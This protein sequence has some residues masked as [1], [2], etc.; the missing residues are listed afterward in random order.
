MTLAS[1]KSAI[2]VALIA[3]YRTNAPY[4]PLVVP[5]PQEVRVRMTGPENPTLEGSGVL[6]DDS[7]RASPT[8][9]AGLSQSTAK[10]N[11]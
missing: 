6:L 10:C 2:R 8:C 3:F 11:F 7:D 1:F 9:G 4:E 5:F